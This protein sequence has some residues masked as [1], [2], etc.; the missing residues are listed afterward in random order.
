VADA[1]EAA[2][3]LTRARAADTVNLARVL[4]DGE[5]VLVGIE[6][7]TPGDVGASGPPTPTVLDLNTSTAEQLDT[8]PGV[9][10]V[11]AGRIVAWR[12]ANGR[13]RSIEELGEVAGIGESILGQVRGLVRV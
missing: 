7:A 8:L 11:L 3:G 4:T 6:K 1:I 13:F 12:T 9:G 10:P 5:Q 2:G